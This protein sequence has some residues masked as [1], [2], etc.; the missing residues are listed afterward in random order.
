MY[1]VSIVAVGVLILTVFLFLCRKASTSK[2]NS[3]VTPEK[4]P[5]LVQIPK[6]IEGRFVCTPGKRKFNYYAP[7]KKFYFFRKGESIPEHLSLIRISDTTGLSFTD[8]RVCDIKQTARI[9]LV[10][11]GYNALIDFTQSAVRYNDI[12]GYVV[13]GRPALIVS[14]SYTGDIDL[15]ESHCNDDFSDCIYG[16]V[17]PDEDT[18]YLF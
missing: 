10:N 1:G 5:R 3:V 9:D 15:L 16:T 2:E 7:P 14:N 8:T 12:N 18:T 4:D 17:V 6:S 13:R 11:H